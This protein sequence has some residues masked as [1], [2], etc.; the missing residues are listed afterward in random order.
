MTR[1]IR[2]FVLREGR[3]TAAQVKA[4][5]DLWPIYGY[6][7]IPGDIFD[8]S[9]LF[10][11]CQ[12]LYLEI[13]FGNGTTLAHLAATYPERNFLGIEVHRPG[14]GHL[15]LELQRANHHNV[16]LLRQDAVETIQ[17]LPTNCLAG[18]YI[19]F[20]D[21]WPKARH[22]KRRLI[23]PQFI[24]ALVQCLKVDG[25]LHLATDWE[26]YAQWMLMVLNACAELKN[27]DPDGGYVERPPYRNLTRFEQRGQ[28]LG[29][30]V[31]DILFYRH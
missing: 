9:Q 6:D 26:D 5:V 30:Q 25:F 12:P 20:P 22:H 11:T 24:H 10:A 7:L 27:A 29:H 14:I 31:R 8:P 2:S 23:Q 28:R 17:V 18:I 15:L 1:H 4:C 19:L 3:I 16:R 13:G 21:P